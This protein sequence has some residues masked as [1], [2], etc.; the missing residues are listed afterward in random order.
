[1]EVKVLGASPKNL[2]AI[3]NALSIKG[4]GSK[5]E[6]PHADIQYKEEKESDDINFPFQMNIEVDENGSKYLTIDSGRINISTFYSTRI[7][8]DFTGENKINLNVLDEDKTYAVMMFIDYLGAGEYRTQI[9]FADASSTIQICPWSRGLFNIGLGEIERKTVDNVTYYSI[10]N[11]RIYSDISL[12]YASFEH[13]FSVT[14]RLKNNIHGQVISSLTLSDYILNIAGGLVL[15][16]DNIT[17]IEASTSELKG[18]NTYVVLNVWADKEPTITIS[19]KS[20]LYFDEAGNYYYRIA[21]VLFGENSFEI[22]QF[23]FDTLVLGG[24]TFTV[25][26]FAGDPE[27]A[28]LYNKFKFDQEAGED[29][30]PISGYART[31][32]GGC[33]DKQLLRTEGDTDIYAYFVKPA[34]SYKSIPGYE[35]GKDNLA[36]MVEGGELKWDEISGGVAASGDLTLSG[37][38]ERVF[39][40]SDMEDDETGEKVKTLYVKTENSDSYN[41]YFNWLGLSENGELEYWNYNVNGF[42]G[43]ES[44]QCLDNETGEPFALPTEPYDENEIYVLAGDDDAGLYWTPLFGSLSGEHNKVAINEDDELPDFLENKIFID[45]SL[46]DFIEIYVSEDGTSLMLGAKEFGSGI[47]ALENGVIKTLTAPTTGQHVLTVNEGIFKWEPVG[48]CEGGTTN[49]N[50]GE[51]GE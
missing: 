51:S 39:G 36:L 28:F 24:D 44:I 13:P 4:V 22:Q 17:Q 9:C 2:R 42:T 50:E 43:I 10:K 8:V 21:Y 14:A 12:S 41:G 46:K 15:K 34:F 40:L 35:S 38:I 19:D 45:E 49:N 5:I 47:V 31:Y 25:K 20:D 32:I 48:E 26:T 3:E 33:I 29:N 7:H 23:I 18:V 6:Y 1:M 11:Q 30:Y 37:S 16:P 27:P